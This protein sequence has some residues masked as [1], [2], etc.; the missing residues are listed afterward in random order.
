MQ[1]QAASSTIAPATPAG[2]AAPIGRTRICHIS[3][4]HPADDTRIFW[5]ECRGLASL[6]YH[7]TLI[8]R[9]ATSQ[10]PTFTKRIHRMTLGVARAFWQA[11]RARA[12]VYHV[13]DPE[14]I[15][16]LMLLR[17]VGKPVIYDAHE[18]LPGQVSHKAYIKPHVRPIVTSLARGLEVAVSRC[19]TAI[20][21]ATPR[22]AR[23]FP[24]GKTTVV[25]NYPGAG[26]LAGGIPPLGLFATRHSLRF[27]YVGGITR[28]R[29][30]EQL[31]EALALV[32]DRY[33]ATL[34]CA[35]P[36]E[37]PDFRAQIEH[38]PGWNY[39]N[40]V[41]RIP[42][43]QVGRLLDGARAGLVTF[44]PAPNHLESSPN[45]FFEYM[46]LG[47]PLIA[48]HFPTWTQLIEDLDCGRIVDPEDPADIAAAMIWVIEHPEE[49][50]AM[51]RRGQEATVTTFNWETQLR[52]L[53]ALYVRVGGVA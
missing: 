33:S 32:N 51:G 40:Y 34:D 45:K 1:A 28:I 23:Q 42:H 17:I 3:T 13:H 10:L 6:G 18:W 44:L 2:P 25:A 11:W 12:D 48:S 49:A 20:V 7:V 53:D 52:Q 14:L 24:A 27:V 37:S 8:A 41:G 39:V 5:R 30:I 43:N 22:I 36:F 46:T 29:G 50:E 47:L 19:A 35:G 16:V 31:V 38:R 9:A 21:T 26:E 4:V 15:P